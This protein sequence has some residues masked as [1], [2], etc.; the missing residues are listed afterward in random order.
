MYVPTRSQ[1]LPISL[2]FKSLKVY[3]RAC[4]LSMNSFAKI[5]IKHVR[6]FRNLVV[7]II[8][9]LAVIYYVLG[10]LQEFSYLNLNNTISSSYR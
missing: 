8:V 5:K 2:S 6:N 10:T 1:F 3:I 4:L 7:I 9:V